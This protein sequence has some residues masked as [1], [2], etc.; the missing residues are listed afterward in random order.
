MHANTC[1]CVFLFHGMIIS[2]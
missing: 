2:G 1:T